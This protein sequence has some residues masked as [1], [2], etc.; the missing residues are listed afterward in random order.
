MSKEKKETKKEKKEK[1][2]W[3]ERAK[4]IWLAG[5]GAL[6]AVEEEGGKLFRSLVDRGTSY[7]K[8]RKEQMDKLWK[9]VSARY[10]K[11]EGKVGE[12]FDKAEDRVEKNLRSIMSGMGIP[13]R[14]EIEDLSN[15]VDALN[16][17]IDKIKEKESGSGA[18][19]SKSTGK[20]GKSGK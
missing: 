5:L 15:K 11:T 3:N 10:E 18:S 14:K 9:E 7:E 16:R 17:K 1:H 20:S 2:E 6:A 8:K 13:T 19:G 12:S 4:E